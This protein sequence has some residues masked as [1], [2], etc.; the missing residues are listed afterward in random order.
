MTRHDHVTTPLTSPTRRWAAV[1][2]VCS[3]IFLLGMDFTVLNVAI[4]DL[5]RDLSPSMAQVQWIVDGYALVLGGAVLATGAV[6]DHIGRRRAFVA[7]LAV[8]G[9][10][11][12]WAP[13][14]RNH[15]S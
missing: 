6:T 3:G 5:Q 14:P 11:P 1:I 8:C 9:S 12:H 15:G 4:P 13:W 2:V 10:P 7:G